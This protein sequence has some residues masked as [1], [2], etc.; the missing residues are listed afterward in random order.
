MKKRERKEG[1]EGSSVLEKQLE[2]AAQSHAKRSKANGLAGTGQ[3]DKRQGRH[4]VT[5]DLICQ[6]NVPNEYTQAGVGMY[7]PR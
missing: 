1:I 5:Y 6:G 7:G 2:K 4:A 3:K